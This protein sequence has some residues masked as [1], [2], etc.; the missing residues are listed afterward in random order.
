MVSHLN[1]R[2]QHSKEVGPSTVWRMCCGV[3]CRKLQS[4]IGVLS[5]L[6]ATRTERIHLK[7]VTKIRFVT[8]NII[9]E[10]CTRNLLCW[11]VIPVSVCLQCIIYGEVEVNSNVS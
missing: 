2:C 6:R 8:Q 10:E 5:L 1:V 11:L 4:N 9:L 3:C 7:I